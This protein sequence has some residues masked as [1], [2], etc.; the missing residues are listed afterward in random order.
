MEVSNTYALFDTFRR[1]SVHPLQ[2]RW[3]RNAQVCP[4]D[5]HTRPVILLQ[6]AVA[7]DDRFF[8]D[9]MHSPLWIVLV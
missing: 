5:G 4:V 1:S 9:G 2:F 8:Q 7:L 6:R 3:R